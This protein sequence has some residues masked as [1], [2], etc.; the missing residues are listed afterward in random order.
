MADSGAEMVVE[1]YC[2]TN[3]TMLAFLQKRSDEEL[4]WSM[5]SGNPI[6]WHAWHVARWGDNLQAAVPGM[7]PVLGQRLGSGVQIWYSQGIAE[8]WGFTG[9]DLG[10]DQTGMD[11][12]DEAARQLVFP[13]RTI[14]LDYIKQVFAA[15]ER[16]VSAI[17]AEQFVS[18][19][20]PQPMTEGIWG[21]STVGA[22]VL[23]HVTHTS[24]HLGMMEA[25]LGLQ[26]QR[27]TATQ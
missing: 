21:D 11:M 10:Y 23:S 6:A 26:G 7:T 22:A 2:K 9:S 3:R 16:A 19:E 8:K 25:L 27:G 5:D 12:S 18:R 17:D 20:Q 24:R 1:A 4:R 15:A 13:V 14:L